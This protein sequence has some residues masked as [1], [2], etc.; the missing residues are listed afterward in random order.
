MEKVSKKPG[1]YFQIL[2]FFSRFH[3]NSPHA[4]EKTFASRNMSMAETWAELGSFYLGTKQWK[5]ARESAS[6]AMKVDPKLPL[7]NEV[8]GF[9]DMGEGKDD[10]AVREFSQAVDSDGHMYLSLFAKTMLSPLPHSTSPG[11]RELFRAALA[12][13]LDDNP[14]FAP[15]YVEWA[16]SFAAE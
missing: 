6:E 9:L 4:D 2:W 15:A 5:E 8:L 1:C 14:Q 13:V 3:P 16:K 11:D 10:L 7:A 12:K